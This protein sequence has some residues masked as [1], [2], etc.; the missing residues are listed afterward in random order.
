MNVHN[1]CFNGEIR[2]ISNLAVEKSAL[3][4][5]MLYNDHIHD[6]LVL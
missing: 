3:V 6:I 4:R 1:M 2:N 5:T